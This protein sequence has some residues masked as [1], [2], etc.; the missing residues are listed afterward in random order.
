MPAIG[1]RVGRGLRINSVSMKTNAVANL[2]SQVLIGLLSMAALPW[3]IKV[4]GQESYAVAALFVAVQ[5]W[6]S[7]LDLGLGQALARQTA[8]VRVA[9]IDLADYLGL[10]RAVTLIF[11]GGA[12]FAT[13]AVGLGSRWLATDWLN[14]EAL[15]TETIAVA[16]ALMGL[17][18]SLRWYAGLSRGVIAGHER[19]VWLSAT[20]TTLAIAR[21]V[22]VIPFL[23]YLNPTEPLITYMQ[24][25]AVLAGL[26]VL[27]FQWKATTLTRALDP[28]HASGKA[29]PNWTVVRRQMSFS[30]NLAFASVVW[31]I[32]TQS[33]RLTLSGIL[34]LTAYAV[35]A[36]ATTLAGA[37]LMVSAPLGAVILPRLTQ[38]AA[39]N[40]QASLASSYVRF[41]RTVALV[42][43]PVGFT[44]AAVS[45]EFL[46]LWTNDPVLSSAA[47]PIT[48]LYCIGNLVLSVSSFGF[49]LQYALGTMRLHTLASVLMALILVP[50]Q[51]AFSMRWG[52]MGAAIAWAL[53]N[54]LYLLAWMPVVHR[55]FL[56]GAHWQW[57][58]HGVL[59][60]G[61]AIGGAVTLTR[62]LLDSF[63]PWPD[64]IMVGGTA[65][66]AA[67][68]SALVWRSSQKAPT[69]GRH[70]LNP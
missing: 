63:G 22:L 16:L 69:T 51:I 29:T 14:A 4:L 34:P 19:F 54:I 36:L 3:L 52:G 46:L 43:F 68:V 67:L 66:V 13:I 50:M 7:L 18:S 41:T 61:F 39:R 6:I 70:S 37:I 44:L 45:E 32:V 20:N 24:Y 58:A 26:E 9:A 12:T 27:L 56:G 31:V 33:D 62:V 47:A 49:Y 30:L 5:T 15:S 1:G 65:L 55:A 40:D 35:F 57:L 59:V 25:Q 28:T 42:V 21:W 64:A 53:V 8:R 2:T 10:Y 17:A 48:S 38:V 23:I 60:P 11:I